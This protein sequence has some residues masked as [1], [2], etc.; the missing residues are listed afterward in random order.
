M[1]SSEFLDEDVEFESVERLDSHGATSET[2]IVKIKGKNYFMKRLRAEFVC[3]LRFHSI[4]NKEYEV[5]SS[6]DSEYIPK[7]ER[8]KNEDGEVYILMEYIIGENIDE[9]LKSDPRYFWKEKNV[10]RMLLQLLK[11]L[12]ELHKKDIIYSDMNP[13]N[14]MLTKYGNNVKICDLGFCVNASFYQTAG[15]TVG[16]SAPEVVAKRLNEIDAQSD[17]YSLGLL[18]QYIKEHSGAKFSRRINSFMERCLSYDKKGRFANCEEAIEALMK[19]HRWC[20]AG[21]IVSV[22][23]IV[24][25]GSVMLLR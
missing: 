7:Y 1:V 17:I 13:R 20:V 19:G 18:L 21:A 22:I 23:A 24:I 8:I 25:V 10:Y 2:F 9:R 5:G 14:V 16:F 6:L 15:S 4:F 12:S 3:D 11:G